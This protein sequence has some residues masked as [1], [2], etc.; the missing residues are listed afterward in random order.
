MDLYILR[1]I[2]IINGDSFS[3][4]HWKI[5]KKPD[6]GTWSFNVKEGYLFKEEG[7]FQLNISVI[8]PNQKTMITLDL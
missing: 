6:W 3:K 8:A 1:I 7:T 2:S 4:L 5:I